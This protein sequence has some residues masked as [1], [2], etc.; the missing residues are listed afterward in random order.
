MTNIMENLNGIAPMG[1]GIGLMTVVG[2]C[3][4]AGRKNEA[5]YY[6]RKVCVWAEICLI[7][8]CVLVYLAARPVTVIAAMEPESAA[9]CVYMVGW[10]TVCKPIFWVGSFIPG[11]GMR[12]AGD[13]KFS[14]IVSTITMW[15]CRV[16]LCI[17]LVR[18]LHFGPMAVWIGMFTDW[19]VRSIIFFGR[20]HSRKWL[21]HR[22]V[23]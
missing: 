14:M 12:A 20:F 10:I 23:A 9:L 22:V 19:G 3:I 6:I 2:Q 15:L 7:I 16:S 21:E 13:V 8:S 17:F 1:M 18:A 11:Y 5:V 4:G